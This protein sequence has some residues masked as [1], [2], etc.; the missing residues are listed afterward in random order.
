MDEPIHYM[1]AES[2]AELEKE[3]EIIKSTTIPEIAKRIDEAKE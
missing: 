1:T 3:Y 2:L